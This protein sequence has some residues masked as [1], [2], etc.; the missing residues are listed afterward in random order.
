MRRETAAP[1]D[2]ETR[3][4]NPEIVLDS[5]IY[6]I[7]GPFSDALKIHG[8]ESMSVMAIFASRAMWRFN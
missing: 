6:L 4:K 5:D 1:T 7:A 2:F 8:S 3:A